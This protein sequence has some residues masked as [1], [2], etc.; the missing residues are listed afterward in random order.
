MR[1][2]AGGESSGNALEYNHSGDN[3]MVLYFSFFNP[4]LNFVFLFLNYKSFGG[5]GAMGWCGFGFILFKRRGKAIQ[6]VLE[7]QGWT[8]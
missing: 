2:Q 5:G 6:D 3:H 1:G 7:L 4:F 8:S